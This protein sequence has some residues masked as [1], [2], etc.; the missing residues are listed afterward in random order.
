MNLPLYVNEFTFNVNA[1][2]FN[3]ITQRSAAS[4]SLGYKVKMWV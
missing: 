3:V 2:T 4:V 1:F